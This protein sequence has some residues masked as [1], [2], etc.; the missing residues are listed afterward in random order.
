MSNQ[1]SDA[2]GLGVSQGPGLALRQFFVHYWHGISKDQINYWA[3]FYARRPPTKAE[4]SNIIER[5]IKRLGGGYWELV[6]DSTFPPNESLLFREDQ[7]IAWGW[8]SGPQEEPVEIK[9]GEAL[10]R[11]VKIEDWL[12]HPEPHRAK[13]AKFEFKPLE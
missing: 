4:A 7:D 12:E 5:A 3:F 11:K 9:P 8:D 10:A 2:E 1:D 13:E 6:Q